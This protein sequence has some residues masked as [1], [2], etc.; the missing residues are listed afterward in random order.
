MKKISKSHTSHNYDAYIIKI[1]DN[2]V[3]LDG[4]TGNIKFSCMGLDNKQEYVQ[5][6]ISTNLIE[7]FNGIVATGNEYSEYNGCI[8]PEV[9]VH[10]G[11]SND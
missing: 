8:V 1:L 2:N 9:I 11:G 10:L 3:I 4:K 6:M 5:C 7:F